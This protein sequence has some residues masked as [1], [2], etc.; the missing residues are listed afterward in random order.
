MSG[1]QEIHTSR[2][3]YVLTQNA[4]RRI[5][6]AREHERRREN[7]LEK[8]GWD[9]MMINKID[10][11]GFGRKRLGFEPI[12]NSFVLFRQKLYI[13]LDLNV[14]AAPRSAA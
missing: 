5:G 13:T 9:R 10:H 12:K 14:F 8:M 1:T 3:K 11:G 4:N 2:R 7:P 6:I